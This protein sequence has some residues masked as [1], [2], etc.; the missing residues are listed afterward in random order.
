MNFIETIKESG[1]VGA[2]GAGFPTHIKLNT[3]AEYFI[4][5]AAE[6]EPLIETDKYL[7]RTFADELI[8]GVMMISAHLEAKKAVIALK[9]KYKAEITALKEAIT[10][11][12]ADIEIFELRTFYPAGDEQIMVQQVTGRSVPERGIPIEVG[13]VVDNVGTV[14]GIY[15][16]L[17]QGKKTTDKYLSIVGEV[18]EP[19]MLKVPIGTS[20]RE[21]IQSANPTISDYAIIL[22][23]PMMGRVVAE[24]DA[25]DQQI[26]TKTTG[27]V[28]V[29]PKDH[30][31]I[32]R[33]KVSID[34]IKHQARSA[35]I[36]CRMCT[37]LCPRYQIG[38]RIKPHLVM[39]NVWR[40]NTEL[41]TEEFEKSF[42]DAANCCDCGLCEMFS[43]PMGLSPRKVNSYMKGKLRERGITVEK[44]TSPVAREA[45]DLSKVPTDRLISR[46]NLGQY[47]GLHAHECIELNPQEVF[48]PLSQHIGKPAK[49]VKAIGDNVTIGDIIAAADD[50]GLSANIHASVHGTIKD[51]TPLGIR[52]SVN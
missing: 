50:S 17:T 44:N 8:K 30:Y 2:G 3:K 39:R 24:N 11:N 29:L 25:I 34:R 15:E 52:I 32:R 4:V 27:N 9:G 35:C 13:A 42:G 26:V 6:C 1:I 37:D 38:H 20:I 28:I 36:Q 19:I 23:G 47:N 14:I 51:I 10:K 5:N 41:S 48:I 12:H 31:L 33:S 16:A 21:C 40:E 49:A 7:C 18:K 43:C 46:L 22:G 45:V